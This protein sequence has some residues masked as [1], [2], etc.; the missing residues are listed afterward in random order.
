MF[1]VLDH[2]L[3]RI[4]ALL[5]GLFVAYPWPLHGLLTQ[6]TS[7]ALAAALLT[8]A[9]MPWVIALAHK[10][11]ALD[12]PDARR[13]HAVI[14]PRIGGLAVILGVNITLFFNF[15]YFRNVIY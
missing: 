11:G 8:F 13:V 6:G 12:V 14:T 4:L 10:I 2:S 9:L 1:A 5:L 7:L 3:S 15:N